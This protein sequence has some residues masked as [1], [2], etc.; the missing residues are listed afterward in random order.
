MRRIGNSNPELRTAERTRSRDSC[1]AASGSPTTTKWG[2][3]GA[4]STFTSII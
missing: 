3:P 4:T 2:R 1:T